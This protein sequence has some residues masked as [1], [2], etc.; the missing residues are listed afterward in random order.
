MDG[1]TIE[2]RFQNKAV[3]FL[4][5]LQEGDNGIMPAVFAL[6]KLSLSGSNNCF[7]R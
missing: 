3:N 2:A 4:P 7:Q 1:M 5:P 6:L